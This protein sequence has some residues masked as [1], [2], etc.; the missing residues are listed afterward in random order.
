[1]LNNV[2]HRLAHPGV[3]RCQHTL[4]QR[5]LTLLAVIL[6]ARQGK[7]R[8]TTEVGIRGVEQVVQT[9]GMT[10]VATTLSVA[11]T[12]FR[13]P[14][15]ITQLNS[16][17]RHRLELMNGLELR[18]TT[19]FLRKQTLDAGH[20][21]SGQ[22]SIGNNMLFTIRGAQLQARDFGLIPLTELN[23]LHRVA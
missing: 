19:P 10:E 20:V 21:T 8:E 4:Q 23:L 11:L 22:V 9:C 1:M 2:F 18:K 13:D 5:T 12:E 7:I 6:G 3:A 17:N 15:V 16:G 14:T